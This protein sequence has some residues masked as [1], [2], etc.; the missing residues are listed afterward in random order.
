M[1]DTWQREQEH[2]QREKENKIKQVDEDIEQV[3][4]TGKNKRKELD[5]VRRSIADLDSKEGQLLQQLKKSNPQVAAGWEWL[6]DHQDEFE[7]PVFGPPAITCSVRDPRYSDLVQSTLQSGDLL[8][9]T[10]Q[11]RNDHVK[12]SAKF[13]D[14]LKL[15]VN[16]K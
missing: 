2:L 15:A 10:A 12:L 3:M 11:T 8:C 1:S 16:I 14:E 9:F 5:E 4:S 6:R 13:Y 7:K